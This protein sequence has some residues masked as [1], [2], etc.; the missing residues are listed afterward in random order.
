MRM[1]IA[2]SGI[3]IV[4]DHFALKYLETGDLV[5]VLPDWHVAPVDLWAVFP[6]RRLMPAK[7]RVFI[8]AL[9][10]K[11]TGPECRAIEEHLAKGKAAQ[12]PH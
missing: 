11:F 1:A 9:V 2:G 5:R 7:T 10:E 8:D 6:G 12:A 4:T 3:A